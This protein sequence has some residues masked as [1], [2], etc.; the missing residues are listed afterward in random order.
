MKNLC[1]L[2]LAII[3]AGINACCKP[4]KNVEQAR[5]FIVGVDEK[6]GNVVTAVQWVNGKEIF[7]SDTNNTTYTYASK[8]LINN[9]NLYA[10]G[11][12]AI[13]AVY[14]GG[15]GGALPLLWKN[16]IES[17]LPYTY[18]ASNFK[19]ALIFANDVYILTGEMDNTWIP[20][21]A[22]GHLVLYKNG[23]VIMD[24]TLPSAY[25]NA[26]F[27]RLGS[28]GIYVAATT[29]RGGVAT[30]IC[31]QDGVEIFAT[32][33]SANWIT[34]GLEVIGNDVTV[35]ANTTSPNYYCA[36]FPLGN[37][38]VKISDAKSVVGTY[39]KDSVAH[40]IVRETSVYNKDVSI[41]KNNALT[42]LSVPVSST[43]PHVLR[44][45]N[46]IIFDGQQYFVGSIYNDVSYES[47]CN[48]YENNILK[49]T[50]PAVRRISVY[51]AVFY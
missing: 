18:L 7:L 17:A 1:I 48:I 37:G 30:S 2:F 34:A 33:S 36:A 20:S 19:D 21:T 43:Y 44:I 29:V 49:S 38:E 31:Y 27:L 41:W 45:S 10:F 13:P 51:D 32:S 42:T 39:I 14:P 16:G 5:S 12:K 8:A 11:G 40:A 4:S 47:Q 26:A 22:I 15:P 24:K 9:G 25:S 46:P 50:L 6:A 23:V 28:S 3:V 35:F